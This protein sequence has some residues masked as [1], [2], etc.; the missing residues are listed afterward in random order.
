[1]TAACG[2]TSS[3]TVAGPSPVKCQ[4]TASNGTPAFEAPGGAGTVTVQAARECT[5]SAAAQAAWIAITPPTEGQGDGTLRYS[6]QANPAGTPRN[7][8]IN[9]NGQLVEV[10]QRGAPCVFSVDPASPEIDA[11]DTTFELQVRGP[12]GCTWSATTNASWLTIASAAQGSGPGVLRVRAAANSGEP[13]RGVVTVAGVAVEVL[14][15]APGQSPVPSPGPA[16][17]PVPPDPQPPAGCAYTLSPQQAVVP[18][19]GGEG[20]FSVQT[21]SGCGWTALSDAPWLVITSPAAGTGGA[22]ITFRADANAGTTPRT[23]RITVGTAAFVVEQGAATEP[24]PPPPPACTYTVE[25][26]AA[27]VGAGEETGTVRVRA[28]NG[29]AWTAV[30]G[31]GWLT[32]V[33]GASGSGNGEVQYRAAANTETAVRTATLQVAGQTVVI[34]QAGAPQPPPGGASFSGQVENLT[35]S[36]NEITFTVDGD[37]VRTTGATLYAGGSC[38]KVK[39]GERLRGDGTLENG[40][41]VARQIVFDKNADIVP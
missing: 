2:G 15:V 33:S 35:G 16:P 13:R 6:V 28:S 5:W 7:G 31:A 29:C 27:S 17:G 8:A 18:S 3:S 11:S 39:D 9:L 34:T 38:S 10:S 32:V 23:G 26:L 24:P 21:P 1:M 22:R 4:V 20:D 30:S 40:A 41:I 37:L 12:V 36:C 25:P 14:Q 19:T